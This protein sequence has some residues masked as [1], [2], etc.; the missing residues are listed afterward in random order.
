MDRPPGA[1]WY[2]VSGGRFVGSEGVLRA[3]GCF[4]SSIDQIA[5]TC[6]QTD[7]R[8]AGRFAGSLVP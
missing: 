7:K 6:A 5:Q 1:L 8:A 2:Y 4:L 3:V